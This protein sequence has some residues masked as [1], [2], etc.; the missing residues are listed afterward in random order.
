MGEKMKRKIMPP[1]WAI[2]IL[3]CLLSI[4]FIIALVVSPVNAQQNQKIKGYGAS[5]MWTGMPEGW[6]P[7]LTYDWYFVYEAGLSHSTPK[8]VLQYLKDNHK[9]IG[10]MIYQDASVHPWPERSR[11]DMVFNDYGHLIDFVTVF[12]EIGLPYGTMT[13]Q[14]ANDSYDYIK[15]KWPWVKV[16]AF[17]QVNSIDFSWLSEIKADGWLLGA[18]WWYS[19]E[20]EEI[21]FYPMLA[22]GKPIINLLVLGVMSDR[23]DISPRLNWEYTLDQHKITIK[24]K[25]P[26]LVVQPFWPGYE[27]ITQLRL[28]ILKGVK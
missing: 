18:R 8:Y 2:I 4:V 1:L 22:T 9:K 20:F 26:E 24:Y 14:E 19:P 21:F 5:F 6:L 7:P 25:I 23:T 27:A 10:V 3:L 12:E 13:V 15:S 17:P 28:D 11:I 16:Y